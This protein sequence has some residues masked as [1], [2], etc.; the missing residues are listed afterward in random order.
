MSPRPGNPL[1]AIMIAAVI[2]VSGC[3]AQETPHSISPQA[4]YNE[5]FEA[6]RDGEIKL[7]EM[8][9]EK[10][11]EWEAKWQSLSP[12][13]WQDAE[14]ACGKVARSLGQMHD[15]YL[16]AKAVARMKEAV[17]SHVTGIG[18]QVAMAGMLKARNEIADRLGDN[19]SGEQLKR[20]QEQ[21]KAVMTLTPERPLFVVKPLPGSP[22]EKAGLLAG[23][24]I[25]AAG[26]DSEHM[27]SLYGRG[28]EDVVLNMIRGPE[29]SAIY[30]TVKRKNEN[31]AAT[32]LEPIKVIRSKF[33]VNPVEYRLVE[34]MPYVKLTT[35]MSDL[36]AHEMEAALKKA[37]Q[38]FRSKNG[39]AGLILDLRGNTGGQTIQAE[40]IL[41]MLI[42]DGVI[43][44]TRNRQGNQLEIEEKVL[45]DHFYEINRWTAANPTQMQN[46]TTMRANDERAMPAL[47]LPREMPMVVLVDE[48]SASAS[49]IVAGA[50]KAQRPITMVVGETTFGKSVGQHVVELADGTAIKVTTFEFRPGGVPI[51]GVGVTPDVISRLEE[52]DFDEAGNL[53]N[54]RQLDAAKSALATLIA[55]KEAQENEAAA[56]AKR[57]STRDRK[58]MQ[59]LESSL[60]E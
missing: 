46:S 42:K 58:I 14:S 29:G 45:H 18:A 55:R 37:A 27:Q 41:S 31:G 60:D 44:E 50:L 2:A 1:F 6:M 56:A 51:D 59:Q 33:E 24:I 48:G 35:F 13:T 39:K 8:G 21:M 3:E 7:V 52:G 17:D 40:V 12:S 19:P 10:A 16:D 47:I 9:S 43:L 22:A 54:D 20:A 5:C 26:S 49:E 38:E 28:F 53:R 57:N 34:G 30:L 32:T 4:H 36:A 23:D 11:R 15:G 25:E